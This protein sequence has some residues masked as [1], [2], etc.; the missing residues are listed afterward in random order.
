MTNEEAANRLRMMA[1]NLAGVLASD[2]RVLP[3]YQ[4]VDMAIT[5]LENR[6]PEAVINKTDE[7]EYIQRQIKKTKRSWEQMPRTA[8]PKQR[9]DLV[10]K[11]SVLTSILDT[12]IIFH[13]VVRC[14]EC[15]NSVVAQQDEYGNVDLFLCHQ[16]CEPI[17]VD[18]W[19]F[20]S[21]GE[22]KD[23]ANV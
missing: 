21:R 8:P 20:C 22:R 9:M 17:V 6:I 4:A 7:I 15:K 13:N 2:P 10:K 14:A 1:I 16:S 23:E 18:P 19:D 12:L 11:M 5:A 3:D